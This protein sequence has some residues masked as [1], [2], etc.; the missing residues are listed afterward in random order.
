MCTAA[1]Y[2]LAAT[3][4]FV[5]MVALAA[6]L[7]FA[8]LQLIAPL[9]PGLEPI[10][11]VL[12]LPLYNAL[13]HFVSSASESIKRR[14]VAIEMIEEM[15][16]RGTFDDIKAFFKEHALSEP[17]Q[18]S[19]LS[20]HLRA[21]AAFHSKWGEAQKSFQEY[22]RIYMGNYPNRVLF[23]RGRH[24]ASHFME[25]QVLPCVLEA[26]FIL[27]IIQDP[28]SPLELKDFSSSP[29][30]NDDCFIFY[31][32]R[33]PTL[34]LSV[35][36]ILLSESRVDSLRSIIFDTKIRPSEERHALNTE[37]ISPGGTRSR[38]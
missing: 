35:E 21:I 1:L 7:T 6:V 23:Y 24:N 15:K 22:D 4:T 5:A 26:A 18:P 10:L 32:T 13:R 29:I 20:G 27:Q 28:T 2:T 11:F 12:E 3:V 31:D 17:E 38:G 34:H 33:R 30:E 14:H 19:D 9:P 37:I 25:N 36:K 8:R 16:S